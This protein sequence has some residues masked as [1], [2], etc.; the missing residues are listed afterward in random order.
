MK[1]SKSKIKKSLKGTIFDKERF[2]WMEEEKKKWLQ[3]L[4]IKESIEI[5]EGLLDS[6]FVEECRRIQKEFNNKWQRK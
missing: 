5:M 4:S 1:N 3:S 2:T 6:G